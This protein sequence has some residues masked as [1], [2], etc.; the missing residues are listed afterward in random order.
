MKGNWKYEE[1]Y[2]YIFFHRS[3]RIIGNRRRYDRF[4]PNMLEYRCDGGG[5]GDDKKLFDM[6]L[7]GYWS[8]ATSGGEEGNVLLLLVS[9]FWKFRR[10]IY[11]YIGVQWAVSPN[12]GAQRMSESTRYNAVRRKATPIPL[13][14]QSVRLIIR[15]TTCSAYEIR[16]ALKF[17]IRVKRLNVYVWKRRDMQIL[18][19]KTNNLSNI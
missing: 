12:C 3:G 13:F 15:V 4:G 9:K 8:G 1:I 14:F 10:Y 16:I 11:I 6:A 2:I 19:V 5:G 17:I 18:F 7:N